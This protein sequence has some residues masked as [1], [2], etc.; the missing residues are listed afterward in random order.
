[1]AKKLNL[2][3]QAEEI[4]QKA[5]AFGVD[6]NFFFIT[7]F[8]RYMVQ[9]K[10]FLKDMSLYTKRQKLV[11]FILLQRILSLGQT[12]SFLQI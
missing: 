7:T 10:I 5:E 6:K 12:V 2:N 9:L 11:I 3:E 1:M 4:L 8:R